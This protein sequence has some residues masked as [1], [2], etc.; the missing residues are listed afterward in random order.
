MFYWRSIIRWNIETKLQSYYYYCEYWRKPIIFMKCEQIE[1]R[2]DPGGDKLNRPKY[3]QN[4]I[5]L[6]DVLSG[7]SRIW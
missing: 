4:E 1:D 7:V 2:T 3:T 5:N 6:R